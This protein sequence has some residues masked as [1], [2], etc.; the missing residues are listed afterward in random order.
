MVLLLICFLRSK[1]A[2]ED[3]K[4]SVFKRLPP[5]AE[6]IAEKGLNL[7]KDVLAGK[8]IRQSLNER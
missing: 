6:G 5:G 1:E 2:M 3:V 4:G 7:G 8:D